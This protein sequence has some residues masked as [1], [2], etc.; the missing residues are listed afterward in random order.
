MARTHTKTMILLY[1]HPSCIRNHQNDNTAV[2]IACNFQL[3]KSL[4]LFPK[5]GLLL[6]FNY[7]SY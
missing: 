3:E 4:G 5:L 6:P 7:L 1:T 2:P